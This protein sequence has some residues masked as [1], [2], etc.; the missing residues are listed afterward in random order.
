[1]VGQNRRMNFDSWHEEDVA[2]RDDV[3][4]ERVRQTKRAIDRFNQARNDTIER[5]D[6]WFLEQSPPAHAGLNPQLY[7]GSRGEA[8]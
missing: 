6:A 7:S 3:G 5:L 8:P 2:R 1:M 4:A